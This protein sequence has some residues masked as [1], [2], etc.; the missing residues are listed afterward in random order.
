MR[1]KS[2][3]GGSCAEPEGIGPVGVQSAAAAGKGCGKGVTE[4][5]RLAGRRREDDRNA[6]FHP[7]TNV[8]AV[9]AVKLFSTTIISIHTWDI[10]SMSIFDWRNTVQS[11][12]KMFVR[13]CE[14][15]LPALA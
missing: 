15:F 7:S 14:K 6:T 9:S 11:T 13:G 4:C 2:R 1:E 3:E 12:W 5:T 8:A 10:M